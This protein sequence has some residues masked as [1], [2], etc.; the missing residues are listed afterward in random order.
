M[1][2]RWCGVKSACRVI[3]DT[4][5]GRTMRWWEVL[6]ENL[7]MKTIVLLLI[8]AATLFVTAGCEEEGHEHQ[9]HYGGGYEGSYRQYGH[10]QSPGYPAREGYWDRS[11]DWHAR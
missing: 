7:N 2:V 6:L 11:D 3:R 1:F 5:H 8:G 9:R 10:D 4:P